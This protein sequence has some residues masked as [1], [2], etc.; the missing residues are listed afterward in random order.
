VGLGNQNQESGSQCNGSH[1]VFVI[2]IVVTVVVAYGGCAD[3][4]GHNHST[5]DLEKCWNVKAGLDDDISRPSQVFGSEH[6]VGIT[7]T[8][9]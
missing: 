5:R 9:S 4:P 2:Y 8:G 6:D 1:E 7:L 3:S